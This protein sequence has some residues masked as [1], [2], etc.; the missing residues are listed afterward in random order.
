MASLIDEP[1]VGSTAVETPDRWRR[2]ALVT[3]F[4]AALVGVVALVAAVLGV[5]I[6]S[7]LTDSRLAFL[8]AILISVTFTCALAART[9]GQPL[10]FGGLALVLGV[11]VL[12]TEWAFL[13]TGVAVMTV[14][15]AGV[16][17]V[18][19]TVPAVRF[20]DA[21]REVVLALMI[22]CIGAVAA[23][24]YAPVVSAERFR[25]AS[26]GAG[27]LLVFLVVYRLGA[28]FHGLGRRGF[29]LVVVGSVVLVLSLVYGELLRRYGSPAFVDTVLSGA[30]RV[31]EVI[32][33]LP[34]PLMVLLGVPALAWGAHMRARRRQ[35]WWISAFG[36]AATISPGYLLVR[37]EVPLAEVALQVLY[38]AALGLLIGYLV[39]RFDLFLTHTRGSRAR[40]S[41]EESA[42]RPE[43]AR[44]LPL[45]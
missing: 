22:G 21:A 24:G 30:H 32:G 36:V 18:L 13:R 34:R 17:A 28:G 12:V 38:S 25:Y 19:Q 9:G 43:P 40:R 14:V 4:C 16:L 27:F 39:I 26:L 35:G 33:A 10:I 29:G 8:G 11:I 37:P 20:R 44:T 3:W 31:W 41:E 42:L 45:R 6:G 1:R 15:I 2:L 23:L 5:R 7:Q